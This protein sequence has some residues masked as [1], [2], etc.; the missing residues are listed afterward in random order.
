MVT[1]HSRR[2]GNFRAD[3]LPVGREQR[4]DLVRHR[5]VLRAPTIRPPRWHVLHVGQRPH[6]PAEVGRRPMP[7]AVVTEDRTACRSRFGLELAGNRGEL[8]TQT[9]S[10][11][12]GGQGG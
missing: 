4:V 3:T 7:A 10:R 1:R 12:G 5:D 11:R 9:E 8:S 6:L 2:G